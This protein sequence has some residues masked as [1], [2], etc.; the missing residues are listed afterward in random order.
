MLS[1]VGLWSA[2]RML[3][4][5]VMGLASVAIF[6]AFTQFSMPWPIGF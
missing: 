4:R 6:A 1:S 5:V 3:K 2:A